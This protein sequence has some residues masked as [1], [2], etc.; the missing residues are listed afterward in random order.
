MHAIPQIIRNFAARKNQL[1]RI[2]KKLIT[3]LLIILLL[4]SC[5]KPVKRTA[6]IAGQNLDL[7][8]ERFDSA[9]WQLDSTRLSAEFL[10]LD[11]LYPGMTRIYMQNVMLMGPIDSARAVT[12]YTNFHRYPA[13]RDVYQ[14][15][16]RAYADVSDIEAE[17]APAVLRAKVFFPNIETPRFLTHISFFNQ[18]VI[19]GQGFISL[20]LDNYMGPDYCFYDSLGVYE[21]LRRN[22]VR[23][24]IAS[25]YLKAWLATEMQ[26]P[27]NANLLNEMI[28]YGKVLYA[29]SCLLPETP[30]S[31]L[32]GY[33]AEQMEWARNSEKDLW[34]E[35]LRT[36]AI[37]TT[38]PIDKNKYLGEG[39]FTQ[40]FGQ[41]SPDRLG[42]YLGW[43]IVNSYMQ[44][45]QDVSLAALFEE[46]NGQA[47]LNK[48]KY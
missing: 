33:T 27:Q 29:V 40:P 36:H 44:H 37:Y 21:Y 5:S 24:K 46:P 19:V 22:M 17:L 20:S 2:M 9:F 23:E 38:N 4:A 43:Q 7:R 25:D 13:V 35:M 26:A 16:E 45:N 10:R 15:V 1:H 8:I 3:P 12:E 6:D 34:Q 28:F 30:D 32:I 18:N 42:S 47:I 48:S 41:D 39:P 31:L 11:T 14:S